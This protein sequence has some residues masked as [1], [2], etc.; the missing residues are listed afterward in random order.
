ML[1][2]EARA[3]RLGRLESQVGGVRFE[4]SIEDAWRANLHLRTAIRVLWR[5]ARFEAADG[6]ALYAGVSAIDWRR[7]VRTDGTLLV[8]AQARESRL[9]HSR[10]IE[11]RTKD[12]IADQFLHRDGRR[13]SV[14]KEAPDL[15][16]HV[17]LWRDRCT[18][19][20]DTSGPSLHKRGWRRFQ[21]RAPLAETLA[22]AVLLRAGW[23]ASAP[24]IDPFCGSGTILVEAALLGL[25]IPPGVFRGEDG[26]GFV[27]FPGHDAGAWRSLCAQVLASARTRQLVLRGSDRDASAVAGAI[28]NL[29]AAGLEGKVDVEVADA[30]ELEA[31]RR[32]AWIVTN[33][34]Y[35]ERVGVRDGIV[36]LYRRFGARLRE[37]C[38][39]CRA[40]VLSRNPRLGPALALRTTRVT[41]LRNGALRCELIEAE[42]PER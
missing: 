4:G 14:D 12:A 9:Y 22:A 10:F 21:G 27:R 8:A 24:L 17:H 29:A 15:L 41:R 26:F 37:R 18:V 38:Q 7:F 19:S 16:V 28:E 20:A 1:H 36:D 6:D 31:P 42:V 25:G 2:R 3:L 34:P 32:G 13:P 23:D 35:G 30:L 11:Q 33:P 40:A 5:L 39:G